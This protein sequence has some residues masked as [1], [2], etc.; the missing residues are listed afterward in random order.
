[1]GRTKEDVA[2]EVVRS[3]VEDI[4]ARRQGFADF[5]MSLETEE[6]REIEDAWVER[7]WRIV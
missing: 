6:R 3:L 4:M 7:I 2:K 1:M 5:W